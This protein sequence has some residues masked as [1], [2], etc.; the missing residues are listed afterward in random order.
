MAMALFIQPLN[1]KRVNIQNGLI[2]PMMKSREGEPL[3]STEGEKFLDNS[4][5]H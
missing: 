1:E 2:W 5:V 4:G 3:G